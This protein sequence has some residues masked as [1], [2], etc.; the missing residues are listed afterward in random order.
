MNKKMYLSP[1]ADLVT[2][3]FEGNFCTSDFSSDKQ[4]Q[5]FEEDDLDW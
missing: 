4:I 3:R 1:E 2:V 5:D